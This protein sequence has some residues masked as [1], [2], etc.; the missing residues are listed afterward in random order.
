MR[1]DS[2]TFEVEIKSE[3]IK[4]N[5]PPLLPLWVLQG[6]L[7]L[8]SFFSH[9]WSS[10]TLQCSHW[11]CKRFFSATKPL[12]PNFRIVVSTPKSLNLIFY[13]VIL[14]IWLELWGATGHLLNCRFSRISVLSAPFIFSTSF[15]T[16]N[17][18]FWFEA[19]DYQSP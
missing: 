8:L 6:W 11:K 12:F 16:P 18:L 19:P 4:L 14:R 13:L 7:N 9:P 15:F 10:T 2:L 5:L 3:P 17:V 1:S